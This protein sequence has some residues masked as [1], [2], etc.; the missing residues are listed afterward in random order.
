MSS[1]EPIMVPEIDKAKVAAARLWAVNRFPYLA[2]ALFSSPVVVAPGSG[3]VAVDR[4]WKIYADPSVVDDWSVP[5]IGSWMVHLSGH[6]IRDHAA[7][8]QE[9]AIAD[10]DSGAWLAA[11]DAEINDDLVEL[12]A[13]FPGTPATPALLGEKDGQLAEHYFREGEHG[14]LEEIGTCD[15]G[16]GC[17][18]KPRPWDDS[19]GGM[20][21][22][23]QDQVKRKVA[24]DVVEEAKKNGDIPQ[25]LLR[26]AEALVAPRV[27]WRKLLAAEIRRGLADAAGASDYSYSRPSRR[28]SVLGDVILPSLRDPVPDVSVVCDTSGS[29]GA[30]DLAKVLSEVEGLILAVGVRRNGLR[31]LAVDAAVQTTRRVSSAHQVELTGGGGTDMGVGIAEAASAKPPPSVIVVLTDGYTPWPDTPPKA[32]RVIVGLIGQHAPES[33]PWTRCVRIDEP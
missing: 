31:V 29:M 30:D 1:I 22:D 21:D 12:G 19:S 28:S 9:A 11:A 27:D 13:E 16:S 32:S 6:L 26:W 18:G 14:R 15:C 24:S 25:S 2:A 8:A 10:E 33:P 7:R 17:D 20:S 3:T 5:Q 23:Q 4:D